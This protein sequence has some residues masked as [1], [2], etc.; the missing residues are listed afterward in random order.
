MRPTAGGVILGWLIVAIACRHARADG[1]ALRFSEMQGGYRISV[2][3]AP[4]PFRKGPVDISVL[5]QNRATGEPI[6]SAVASVR[7]M[8]PGQPTLASP[9]TFEAATNKLFRAVQFELPASGRW[10][11]QIEVE[12]LHGAATISG[13]VEAAGALPRWQ[14]LWLWIAWPAVA[15]VLFAFHQVLVRRKLGRRTTRLA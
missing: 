12:G 9:A 7:L 11:M 14:E 15:I 4:V 1:G 8:Q 2:F 10:E 13:A 6:P 3:T 5:V